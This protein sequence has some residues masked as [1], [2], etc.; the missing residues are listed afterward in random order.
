MSKKLC[1]YVKNIKKMQ[2]NNEDQLCR[3]NF[4]APAQFTS[5]A[6]GVILAASVWNTL[7]VSDS[8][9]ESNSCLVRFLT[10]EI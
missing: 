9:T 8:A 2:I 5:R 1:Y 10:P 6:L 3:K 7:D 4:K